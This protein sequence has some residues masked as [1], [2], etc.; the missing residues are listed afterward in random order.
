MATAK[1]APDGRARVITTSS[2][3]HVLSGGLNF[4]TFKDSQARRKLSPFDLYG[5]SKTA[6]QLFYSHQL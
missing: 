3:A 5:Q 1:S 2:S 6:R 4:D